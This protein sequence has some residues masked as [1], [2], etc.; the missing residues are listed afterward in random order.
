M[1]PKKGKNYIRI[2]DDFLKFHEETRLLHFSNKIDMKGSQL[3]ILLK[4][5]GLD[6]K[7]MV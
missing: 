2:Y 3:Q 6:Q 4:D 5:T 7:V 1:P